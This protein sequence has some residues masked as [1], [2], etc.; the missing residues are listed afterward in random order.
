[1]DSQALYAAFLPFGDVLD[2]QIPK[3]QGQ[4]EWRLTG[5]P[6]LQ[7]A[8]L[9]RLH[10]THTGDGR[11]GGGRGGRG[12]RG[13]GRG[14]RGGY[15]GQRQIEDADSDSNRGFG[16]VTFSQNSDALEAI[17]NMHLNELN[18]RVRIPVGTSSSVC[19]CATS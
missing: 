15:G 10:G 9:R 11:D 13:G 18:G 19:P 6:F 16:F 5:W 14:G 7:R 3:N 17:D 8:R 1:M 12:G 2:V 4:R